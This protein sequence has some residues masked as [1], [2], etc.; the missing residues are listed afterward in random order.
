MS[1]LE[2]RLLAAATAGQQHLRDEHFDKALASMSEAL[3]CLDALSVDDAVDRR[4]QRA[5]LVVAQALAWAELDR[6]D[7]AT[8]PLLDALAGLEAH[9]D[10][11]SIAGRT[12]LAGLHSAIGRGWM[13]E[14]RLVEAQAQLQKALA[15]VQGCGADALEWGVLIN[16]GS[17]LAAT[18]ETE[19]A[20]PHVLAAVALVD[21]PQ[22]H[23]TMLRER[24]QVRL[25]LGYLLAAR[26]QVDDACSAWEEAIAMCDGMLA[27][28]RSARR[29]ERALALMNLGS[30]HT[31][32]GRDQAA[33]SCQRAALA[34]VDLALRRAR[35]QA[36]ATRLRALR[37][38]VLMNLGYALFKVDDFDAA[39]TA[40]RRADRIQSKL[41]QS[42]PQV[43]EDLARTWV[44]QAHV[45]AQRG[46]V[47]AS[48]RYYAKGAEVLHSLLASRT[49][50]QADH[51]NAVLGLARMRARQGQI[52]ESMSLFEGATSTLAA[53][54]HSG[55][56]QLCWAWLEAWTAQLRALLQG[57]TA[58]PVGASAQGCATN[59][60]RYADVLQRVLA[61]ALL[62]GMGDGSIPLNALHAALDAIAPWST[63]TAEG[64]PSTAR[65][66]RLIESLLGY[67]FECVADLLADTD[68]GWLA[69]HADSLVRVMS[70]LRDAAGAQ[71]NA[72]RLL[73]D[74]FL[75]TR[76]LRAQ[77]SAIAAGD[78]PQLVALRQ[79]LQRLRHLEDEML[80]EARPRG[81][82]TAS[83]GRATGLLGLSS[84]RQAPAPYQERANAWQSLRDEVEAAR[85]RLVADGSLPASSRLTAAELMTRMQ[86]NS[87]LLMLAQHDAGKVLA[88]ALHRPATGP[89]EADHRV[90]EPHP[91][92]RQFS[93]ARLNQLARQGQ[94]LQARGQVLRGAAQ[95]MADVFDQPPQH[96]VQVPSADLDRFALDMF[97]SVWQGTVLP[98]LQGLVDAAC[99]DIC[100]VASD[101]LQLV[102]WTHFAETAAPTGCRI[103]IYPSSGAWARCRL[104][105][106]SANTAAPR[107]ALAAWSALDS[108]RPLPWVELEAFLSARLWR[109]ISGPP[110]MLR[111]ARPQAQGVGALLGMG[112]GGSPDD[113]PAHAGLAMAADAILGA[114]ALPAIRT[115]HRVVL[116]ACALGRVDDVF[117]EPLGFLSSCFDYGAGFGSAWLTEVPDEAACWASLAMQ[118]ALHAAYQ[119]ADQAADQAANQAAYQAGADEPILWNR[120]FGQ[121]GR[122]ILA[123]AW[124]EGFGSWLSA[125]L[126]AAWDELSP[127]V[128]LPVSFGSDVLRG[129]PAVLRRAMPWAVAF[130]R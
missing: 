105:P 83:D 93:L 102:P 46:Q 129:P 12:T 90:V 85:L 94:G 52:D 28:G 73:V 96:A 78:E 20:R 128:A 6:S 44:N 130:G 92:L 25:N 21:K 15:L 64:L 53:L 14:R 54:T 111:G 48:A 2:R 30:L 86:P 120:V 37:A 106:G 76:G 43:R 18:G 99:T 110:E 81:A 114:H 126:P 115:C 51:A 13:V 112:H 56:P 113:N 69:Q 98:V 27:A 121:V 77:R 8:Q 101:E 61:Q 118:F 32:A 103:E 42:Q 39:E 45:L 33:V 91:D 26:G 125:H 36:A 24:A 72:S 57:E 107:W 79:L 67:L 47:D 22:H 63:L 9:P 97:A 16:L 82:A 58:M 55:Q 62:R 89:A 65:L 40:F 35:R 38:S 23:R 122:T 88:I 75:H 59:L 100:L 80:G 5:D 1:P 10:R 84:Q 29:F 60:E 74:W 123:G 95:A 49:G 117:G 119:A 41:A 7:E 3:Q 127:R 109:D 108:S 11:E 70:R 68:P 19:A 17:V 66:A 87:A 34:D 4:L 50:L 104:Q 71:A 31:R 116:S 124:P